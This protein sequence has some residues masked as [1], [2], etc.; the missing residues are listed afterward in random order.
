MCIFLGGSISAGKPV[1]PFGSVK[2]NLFGALSAEGK[3]FTMHFE[4]VF[5]VNYIDLLRRFTALFRH[6]SKYR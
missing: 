3:L 6:C 2:K 4:L 5:R 1:T